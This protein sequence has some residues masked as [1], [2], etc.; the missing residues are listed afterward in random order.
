VR[1]RPPADIVAL[2]DIL[3]HIAALALAVPKIE[4]IDINPLLVLPRGQGAWAADALV[5]LRS[6]QF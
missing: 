4:Q 2:V 1:G 6:P 5:V 3:E